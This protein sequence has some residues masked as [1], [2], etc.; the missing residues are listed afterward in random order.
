MTHTHYILY[1]IK[2]RS[3]SKYAYTFYCFIIIVVESYTMVRI[4]I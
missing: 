4:K 2:V 1:I 3:F